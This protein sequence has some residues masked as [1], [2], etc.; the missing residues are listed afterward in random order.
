MKIHH[1]APKNH[2]VRKELFTVLENELNVWEELRV[3]EGLRQS[4]D[5]QST[6]K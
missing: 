3:V 6:S 5:D 1:E 2:L 4:Y